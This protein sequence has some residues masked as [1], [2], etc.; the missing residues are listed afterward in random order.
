L[1]SNKGGAEVQRIPVLLKASLRCLQA[2][3]DSPIN[4]N[5]FFACVN[6]LHL[7]KA[8]PRQ[9]NENSD[10]PSLSFFAPNN[11]SDYTA[12]QQPKIDWAVF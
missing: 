3:G 10:P 2:Y 9:L 6:Y 4:H 5:F 12:V 7:A 11:F 8:Q 1:L